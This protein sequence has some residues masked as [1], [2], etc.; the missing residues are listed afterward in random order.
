VAPFV[1]FSHSSLTLS[2]IAVTS[3]QFSTMPSQHESDLALVLADKSLR[4]SLSRITHLAA[5]G[6]DVMV[7]AHEI[8]R[9]LV[10]LF[11]L[12]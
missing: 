4:D 11:L 10:C 2:I 7:Q 5:D 9:Q 12:L 1:A 8:A 6:Q 3:R